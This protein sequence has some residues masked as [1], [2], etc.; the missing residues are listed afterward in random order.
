M[1]LVTLAP[2][3]HHNQRVPGRNYPPLAGKPLIHHITE[4][5]LA[6]PEAGTVVVNTVS[7]L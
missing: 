6:I 3:R 1:K 2:M 7:I 5:L 4:M